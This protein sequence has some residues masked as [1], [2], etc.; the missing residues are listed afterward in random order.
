V[1]LHVSFPLF[2]SSSMNRHPRPWPLAAILAIAFFVST[3]KPLHAQNTTANEGG[4]IAFGGAGSEPG[5]F[6][7]LQDIAFDPKGVLYALDGI[8]M[9]NKIK[10]L[11]GNLR[12]QK[13]DRTGKL[14]GA[15]DLKSAPE[16]EWSEKVQPQHVAADG[17]GNVYVTVPGADAVLVWDG[18]G[19]F[20]RSI[21]I[22]RA[23][24][25]TR[26]GV[27][28]GE[29]LA[30][31]PSSHEVV[32]GKGWTWL[33]GDR[34]LILSP[35]GEI[36]KTIA[37]TRSYE[38]VGDL[39]ADRTGN[40]YLMAEPNAIYQLSPTGQ[41]LKTYGGNPTTR[42]P[43]GSEVL[44]TVDVDSAGN[45]YTFAWGNPSLL[46]RFDAD[47]K[48]VTQRGGQFKWA[49]PWGPH[50]ER[51]PLAID[52]DDRVWIAATG[53][54]D[55]AGVNYPKQRAVPAIVR[56]R[57]D[58]FAPSMNVQQAPVRRLGFRP[59]V[60]S[61]LPFN[62]SYDLN[63]PITMQF[64]VAAANRNVTAT[65]TQWRVFDA[66]KN[67]V[68]RGAFDLHLE[69]GQSAGADFSWTPTRYGSY[70][71]LI[72]STSPD[73]N[74]GAL[75]EHVAVTP[76][77]PGMPEL[78]TESKG[79]WS[80][81]VRQM[82]T[83]LPNVRIHP[84]LHPQDKP[85]DRE[86][87]F[88]A[89]EE[90]ISAAEKAGATFLVQ[91]V[92][93]QKNF[94]ADDV[95][96]VMDR[97]KGRIKYV[98]VCNEP[99]FSG[100]AD[101]YFKIHKAAYEAVKAVDPA[102]QVMGPATV[103]IDLN[104]LRRLYALGF[105]DV[106]DIVSF[107]DY[108]G[109][110]SIDPVHW[111]WKFGEVRQ[112]MA[113]NGDAT[114]QVWQTERAIS[115]VRGLN[116]QGLVQAIRMSLHRDLLETL[117]IPSEH[118]NHY[119]LNQGG[120]SSVPTYVW[121][122][123]GPMPGALVM[124]TR[125]ALTSALHRTYAGMLDFGPTGNTLYLGVRYAGADGQTVALRNLGAPE[126]PLE[127][128]VRGTDTLHVTDAWGNVAQVPVRDGRTSLSI[129]QL[130]IYVQLATGQAIEVPKLDFGHNVAPRAEFVYSSTSKNSIALVNNEIVETY[131]NADPNG[132]TNGAKIWQGNLPTPGQTLEM[133]FPRPQPIQ[134]IIL[135]TPR[136]DNTFTT[137]LDYDLQSWDGA[138]WTTIA[139]LHRPMPPSEAA[140]TADATHAMW[141]D[142]T[143]V[144]IHTF[145]PVVTGKLRL[146]VRE[147][148]RGFISDDDTR[149]WSNKIPQKLMLREVEI[150]APSLPVEIE[151]SLREDASASTVVTTLRSH[152]R[153][154]AKASLYAFAPAGWSVPAVTSIALSATGEQSIPLPTTRPA[155]VESGTNFI[156]LELRGE[157]GELLGSNFLAIQSPTPVELTP[158]TANAAESTPEGALVKL[159]VK[160][161]SGKPLSGTAILYLIGPSEK[162]PIEQSFGPL[163]AGGSGVVSW[164][165]PAL[166]LAKE[167]WSATFEMVANGIKTTVQK[168][169]FGQNWSI[170]GPFPRGFDV[171][172]GPEKTLKFD[173]TESFTDMV[174]TVRRWQAVRPAE[175]G[176]VNLADAIKPNTDVMA[177]AV[178]IVHSPGAQKALFSVGTDDG[179]KGWLNGKVVYADDGTHAASP[180]QQQIPVELQ[181]GANEVW[182]KVTQ[183][184]AGWGFYFD[185]LD[186]QS[187]KPLTDLVYTAQP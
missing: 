143:N 9:N 142:D 5:K 115:G 127:F 146:V 167:R 118:N 136:P 161:I 42:N 121:S 71:V 114:K 107:H 124:R 149:A 52:P 134:Q 148:T 84:G 99:N 163:E 125:H 131:Y 20:V 138:S 154:P 108:E 47:G 72:N 135:R 133:R 57:T 21:T 137:L 153:F 74:L 97:F 147:T 106:S 19:V 39:A 156:D 96:A 82:W 109:H 43:D 77:F 16:I 98:E 101:D 76:R 182:L 27:G 179:G 145:A 180:G 65:T 36:E 116:F 29:R 92:D 26:F 113:E 162:P 62:V 174:G 172:E 30:V 88:A 132:D 150:Y 22:P 173:P 184:T 46:T 68:A 41:P 28:A 14:L 70:F 40:F 87:K 117:G 13:F 12:V 55:P 51:T 123:Q 6:L 175:T 186:P 63:A 168:E 111:R 8:R 64:T 178:A 176:L 166:D 94:K 45:V 160:N 144:F 120:Y 158:Q 81:A 54:N 91:M 183:S 15:I 17:A 78:P 129:G 93:S 89:L 151:P 50:S 11:E 80:D 119:Y 102:A 61:A 110:E 104:W 48:T 60:T 95:R 7:V 112:I 90:N 38:D 164:R 2:Q 56:A 58:F 4:D 85:A 25:I 73:G 59:S 122:A 24:A 177:Y 1:I 169:L 35:K 83:G 66:L 103:N 187:G 139:A 155:V 3:A 69:N 141:M 170:V 126:A 100:T 181:A 32:K 44:H 34:I 18:N 130:P 10:A 157:N 185:L 31:V 67:E 105:K 159:A 165:I 140:V 128:S 49:D 171:P 75:G 53:L 23:A 33:G 152:G 37:L 79:G 86:K